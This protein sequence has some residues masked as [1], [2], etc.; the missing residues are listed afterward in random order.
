[1]GARPLIRRPELERRDPMIRRHCCS[2][3]RFGAVAVAL[4]LALPAL[5]ALADEIE[6]EPYVEEEAGEPEPEPEYA[7]SV[8]EEVEAKVAKSGARTF[9]QIF[10]AIIM[11]PFLFGMTL[12]GGAVFLP[13]A[14]L[15]S[16][17]GADNI[18]DAW[19]TFVA[20][21]VESTFIRPLG[22]P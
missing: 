5:P 18:L 14:V 7:A 3:P 20:P 12:V 8:E 13:A 2:M 22:A 1:V 16:P 11:R 9:D 15:A 4:L 6:P 17:G 21:L 10:D 19:D